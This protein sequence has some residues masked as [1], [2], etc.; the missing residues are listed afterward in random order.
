MINQIARIDNEEI[1]NQ[2]CSFMD[3]KFNNYDVIFFLTITKE[4]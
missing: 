1:L 3:E 4:Y 2:K